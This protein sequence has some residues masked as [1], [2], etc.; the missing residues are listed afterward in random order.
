MS[1]ELR[2][3]AENASVNLFSALN[4]SSVRLCFL[5]MQHNHHLVPFRVSLW[6]CLATFFEFLL[7]AR[8][9]TH[10]RRPLVTYHFSVLFCQVH[11][12]GSK[13]D[14]TRTR[15]VSTMPTTAPCQGRNAESMI[16][17]DV[18]RCSLAV[19]PW[20]PMVRSG[21]ASKTAALRWR[22]KSRLRASSRGSRTRWAWTKLCQGSCVGIDR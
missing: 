17:L 15:R 6:K 9:G 10:M 20:L 8:F 11:G 18:A 5:S 22:R 14:C 2:T 1:S 21:V 13:Y 3:F 16:H 4:L 7:G 12:L 19:R